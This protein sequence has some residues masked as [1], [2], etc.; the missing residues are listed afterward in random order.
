[1]AMLSEDELRD[2][3]AVLALT[4][5]GFGGADAALLAD[6]FQAAGMDDRAARYTREDR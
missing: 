4:L 5:E 6:H 1:M 3:H 2:V